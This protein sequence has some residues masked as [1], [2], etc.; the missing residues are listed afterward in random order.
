M[1]IQ[2]QIPGS[3]MPRLIEAKIDVV[4][5]PF[6]CSVED[7]FEFGQFY[8]TDPGSIFVEFDHPLV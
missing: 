5:R 2:K 4:A 8:P 3:N 7:S 1:L 6:F